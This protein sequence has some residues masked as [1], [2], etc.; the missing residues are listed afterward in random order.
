MRRG[1][2]AEAG[3]WGWKLSSGSCSM[4]EEAARQKLEAGA[5]S[6]PLEA[7][8]CVK[9]PGSCPICAKLEA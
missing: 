9:R 8:L 3:S 4:C 6:C 1:G 2:A 7:V 5:E